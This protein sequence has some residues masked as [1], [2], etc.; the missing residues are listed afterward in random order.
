MV[1][2]IGFLDRLKG[3]GLVV[4]IAGRVHVESRVRRA[5]RRSRRRAARLQRPVAEFVVVEQGVAGG[6]REH[7]PQSLLAESARPTGGVDAANIVQVFPIVGGERIGKGGAVG[8]LTGHNR[9]GRRSKVRR[10]VHRIAIK[11]EIIELMLGDC[12]DGGVRPK[13][14][15][16]IAAESKPHLD[17]LVRRGSCRELARRART[18]VRR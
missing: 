17:L 2:E 6:R 9:H 3:Q 12:A 4:E 7:R 1:I 11:D 15:V 16:G 14:P 13:P 5:L 8:S 18:A 10:L